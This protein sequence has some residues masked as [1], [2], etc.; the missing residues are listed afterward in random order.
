[1]ETPEG[2]KTREKEQLFKKMYDFGMRSS[3]NKLTEVYVG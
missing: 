2:M 3:G 1:M